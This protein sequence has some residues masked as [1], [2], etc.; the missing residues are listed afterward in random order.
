MHG[1]SPDRHPD[2]SRIDMLLSLHVLAIPARSGSGGGKESNPGSLCGFGAGS[3]RVSVSRLNRAPYTVNQQIGVILQIP[4]PRH[5]QFLI[6]LNVRS[7]I[8]N[9]EIREL[10]WLSGLSRFESKKRRTLPF[11]SSALSLN[12]CLL[13]S[14]SELGCCRIAVEPDRIVPVFGLDPACGTFPRGRGKTCP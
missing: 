7:L 2:P 6:V 14:E 13:I 10:K 8:L 11:T 1:Q 12:A 5:A 4:G 9:G 3:R